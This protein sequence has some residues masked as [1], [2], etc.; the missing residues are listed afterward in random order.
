[1]IAVAVD[2]MQV[3]VVAIAVVVGVALVL[4]RRLVLHV[5]LDGI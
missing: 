3:A 1:M 5:H 2:G 4:V